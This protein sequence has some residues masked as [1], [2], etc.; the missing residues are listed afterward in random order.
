[1]EEVGERI[2]K[3]RKLKGLTQ[4]EMA[5]QL[6]ISTKTYYMLE[7][8]GLNINGKILYKYRDMGVNIAWILTGEGDIFLGPDKGDASPS[9]E[10]IGRISPVDLDRKKPLITCEPG[11]VYSSGQS[12][13]SEDNMAFLLLDCLGRLM[14]LE[15][16]MAEIEKELKEW[17]IKGLN[18]D[19]K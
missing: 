10:G 13:A 12:S 14:K 4:E 9:E 18:K 15:R 3:V 17:K 2:R 8:H 11:V 19:E 6:G 16:R 5:R 1:M 7:K